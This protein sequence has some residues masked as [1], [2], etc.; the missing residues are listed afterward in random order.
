MK[1][2]SMFLN[3]FLY[4]TPAWSREAQILANQNE[5]CWFLMIRTIK[6]LTA[7]CLSAEFET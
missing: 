6:F 4:V 3:A 5:Q 2:Q 1:S 7:P